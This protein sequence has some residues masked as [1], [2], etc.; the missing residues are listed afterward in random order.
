MPFGRMT[1]GMRSFSLL[2][3]PVVAL[4]MF[5]GGCG[6]ST[7]ATEDPRPPSFRAIHGLRD[8]GPVD[9]LIDGVAV[10]TAVPYGSA[11][12]VDGTSAIATTPGTHSIAVRRAGVNV[13]ELPTVTL[14]ND[15]VVT[16]AVLGS[17]TGTGAG[18]P[19]LV[20]ATDRRTEIAT[21]QTELRVFHGATRIPETVDLSI[22]RD[23]STPIDSITPTS[24]G[25]GRYATLGTYRSVN[26]NY[27][28]RVTE[29]GTKTVVAEG[30]VSLRNGL[31]TITVL[32]DEAGT[33]VRFS[34][35]G[36]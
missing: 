34:V 35:T 14:R 6:G 28:M 20:G 15:D 9:V 16:L 36:G 17:L 26:G 11:G 1:S 18:A 24:A 12:P 29:A 21:N 22:T 4:A 23:G 2:L 30:A 31:T 27:R 19:K 5:A 33:G 25:L 3:V 7:G 10:A 8:A 32:D 13:L